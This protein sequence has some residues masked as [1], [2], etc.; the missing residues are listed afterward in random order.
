MVF[1]FVLFSNYVQILSDFN[2][3]EKKKNLT[4]SRDDNVLTAVES[5]IHILFDRNIENTDNF[6]SEV[7][8]LSLK[9]CWSIR[10]TISLL[11]NH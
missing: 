1:L 4:R 6:I 2:T 3:F 9:K 5:L 10:Y 7:V 11:F 8:R